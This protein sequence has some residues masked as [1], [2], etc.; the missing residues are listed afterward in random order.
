MEIAAHENHG[1]DDRNAR[2]EPQPR[3]NIHEQPTQT[4]TRAPIRGTLGAT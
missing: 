4:H 3:G 2:E 1:G